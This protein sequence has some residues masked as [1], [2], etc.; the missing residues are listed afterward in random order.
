ML[1]AG[2]RVKVEYVG[3][4]EN[5]EVFDDSQRHG[6]PMEFVI[7]R[8][9]VIPGFEEAVM[10][11]SPGEEREVTLPPE[12]GYGEYRPELVVKIPTEQM[13]ATGKNPAPGMVIK[14]PSGLFGIVTDVSDMTTVDFN[15]PL[16]GKTL[17]FKIKLLEAVPSTETDAGEPKPLE[18]GKEEEQGKTQ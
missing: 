6:G 9:M 3:M 10:Q 1:S 12:K 7:G 4:F 8:K 5:G 14:T 17:K 11:M 15:H 16:A 2:T 13:V 18:E